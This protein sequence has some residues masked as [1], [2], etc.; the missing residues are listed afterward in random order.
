METLKKYAAEVVDQIKSSDE[1]YKKREEK[2]EVKKKFHFCDKELE[3]DMKKPL[4]DKQSNDKQ[5]KNVTKH[6]SKT[7]KIKN[8]SFLHTL[9]KKIKFQFYIKI[10]SK[11]EFFLK[12]LAVVFQQHVVKAKPLNQNN[13]SN[14]S[15]SSSVIQNEAHYLESAALYKEI[16]ICPKDFRRYLVFTIGTVVTFLLEVLILASG[17]YFLKGSTYIWMISLLICFFLQVIQYKIIDSS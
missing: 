3:K 4:E 16:E 11:K 9:F 2:N 15:N 17:D 12:F 1:N 7:K 8:N 5:K 10:L 14:L 6:N 13:L